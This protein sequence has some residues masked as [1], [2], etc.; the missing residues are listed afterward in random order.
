ML[1]RCCKP[2]CRNP[3]VATLTYIYAESQ[4]VLADLSA[5]DSPHSWDLC[6][7]HAIRL[8]PPMGWDLVREWVPESEREPASTPADATAGL[9][10]ATADDMDAPGFEAHLDQSRFGSAHLEKANLENAQ[11]DQAQHNASQVD[12]DPWIDLPGASE[13]PVASAMAR[14]ATTAD[15]D[16]FDASPRSNN[17]ASSSSGPARRA[18]LRIVTPADTE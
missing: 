11:L 10:E 4:V 16:Q 5:L 7:Q 6:E 12:D 8:A 1:R 2:G 3:A 17:D 13:H 9:H 15:D 14:T 18:H